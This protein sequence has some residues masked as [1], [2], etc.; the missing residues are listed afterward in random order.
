MEMAGFFIISPFQSPDEK[1]AGKAFCLPPGCTFTANN[2]K[3]KSSVGQ[4]RMRDSGSFQVSFCSNPETR[5]FGSSEQE[6]TAGRCVSEAA[7]EKAVRAQT[8]RV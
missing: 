7:L 3:D 5:G 6:Q 8:L 4:K 2:N 1:G